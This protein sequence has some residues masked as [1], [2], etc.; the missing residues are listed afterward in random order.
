MLLR[1]VVVP[2]SLLFLHVLHAAPIPEDCKTGGFAVGC[3]AWTF[4]NFTAVEA[5]QK[6]LQAGGKVI[7]F[8]PGQKFS[9]EKPDLKWDHNATDE[10]IARI[11]AELQ[12][13]GIRAVNY[14]VVSAKD[15]AECRKIFEFA[16]KMGLY[17]VTTESVEHM[18]SFE[19]FAKEFD[20]KV[21]IHNHPKRDDDPNYKVW[22]PNYV[23]SI[24]KPRDMRLGACADT[25]HWATS[26]IDP[27]HAV[28]ILKGRI[29]SM[30][31]KDRMVIGGKTTDVPAGKGVIDFKSILDELKAQGFHG[32]ISVEHETNWD[33]SVPDVAQYIGFIRGYAAQAKGG[34][35]N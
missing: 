3:Q 6:T 9:P 23:L 1:F 26:G 15:E 10:M 7:E 11:K 25:G 24:V 30:H 21:A 33:H 8:Y 34:G 19:K 18:D 31:M 13:N 22:D 12:T 5:I 35:A 32:N 27:L 29:I 14:G 16:K 2:C 17:A 4:K 28:R 20:I